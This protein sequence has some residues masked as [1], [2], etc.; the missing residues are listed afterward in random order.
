MQIETFYFIF[1]DYLIKGF[2]LIEVVRRLKEV[3][4]Y[5]YIVSLIPMELEKTEIAIE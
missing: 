4:E 1:F 2:L 5:V 3:V